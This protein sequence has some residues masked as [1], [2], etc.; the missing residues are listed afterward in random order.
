MLAQR[1]RARKKK[2]EK[3]RRE[4]KGKGGKNYVHV[5]WRACSYRRRNEKRTCW[6]CPKN[7]RYLERSRFYFQLKGWL[8]GWRG[9]ANE[10]RSFDSRSTVHTDGESG[11]AFEAKIKAENVSFLSDFFLSVREAWID[12]PSLRPPPESKRA[13]TLAGRSLSG[14]KGL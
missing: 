14:H 7:R 9:F 2:K 1:T 13:E 12:R 11:E 8:V 4:G 3:E 6:T 5:R 10:W